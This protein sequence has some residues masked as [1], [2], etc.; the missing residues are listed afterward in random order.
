MVV[1]A[2]PTTDVQTNN[3]QTT[4]QETD[5]KIKPTEQHLDTGRLVLV[6]GD[7]GG[8]GKSVM[9]RILLDVYR[10]RNIHCIAYECDQSNPQLYRHYSKVSPGVQTL[11]L[12]GTKKV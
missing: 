1:K 11:K 5:Q 6:T 7:K 2:K 12:N 9:A 10:H 3:K 8:A 4:K